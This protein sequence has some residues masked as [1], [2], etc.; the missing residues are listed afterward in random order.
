M[1]YCWLQQQG[2][3]DCLLFFAGWGMCPEPFYALAAG[4]VDVLMVYDYRKM[5]PGKIASLLTR[6]QE[7]NPPYQKFY[8]LAWSM[9]V[10]AAASLLGRKKIPSLHLASAIALGGTC[11]PIHDKLGLPEQHFTDMAE[12]LSPA[13]I[14]AF[15]H[16]MFSDKEEAKRFLTAFQ[17]GKRSVAELQQELLALATAS[18]IQPGP[19]DIYTSKIITGRDRIFP[20][21]NQ[22]RAWGRKQC[23]TLSLPHFPFYHWSNWA[24]MVEALT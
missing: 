10:W 9:G 6:L 23:R 22:I 15:Q 12:Q 5:E 21:R 19:P 2:N 18:A 16:S 14:A 3:P 4:P 11:Q 17:K 13:H 1:K 8:L 20:A 24:A 7:H